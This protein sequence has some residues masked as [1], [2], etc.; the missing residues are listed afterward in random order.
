[1]WDGMVLP[2]NKSGLN[3]INI[4]NFKEG[5]EPDDQRHTQ[6]T[7]NQI[8]FATSKLLVRK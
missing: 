1:M 2:L 4:I 6:T 7:Q 8:I 5:L 3:M